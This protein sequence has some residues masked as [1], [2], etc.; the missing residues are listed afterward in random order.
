MRLEK[1][2]DIGFFDRELDSSRP[3]NSFSSIFERLSKQQS[4]GYSCQSYS[5]KI[6]IEI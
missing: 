2:H 1:L 5:I 3:S 4:G 6:L